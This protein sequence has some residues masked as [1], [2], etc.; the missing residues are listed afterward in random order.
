VTAEMDSAFVYLCQDDCSDDYPQVSDVTLMIVGEGSAGPPPGVW[1]LTFDPIHIEDTG[2]VDVWVIQ[3]EAA[4]GVFARFLRG[5]DEAELVG[6]PACAR[7][8][9]LDPDPGR[10]HA[11][12]QH[13]IARDP[14]C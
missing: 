14:S 6:W 7:A 1:T 13:V 11:D 5:A 2:E 4:P 9:G 10:L 3:E 12:K 8:R